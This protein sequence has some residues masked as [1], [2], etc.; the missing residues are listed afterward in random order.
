M[1]SARVTPDHGTIISEI[2]IAAPPERV[3]KA[4]SDA[5]EIRRRGPNL[6]V[7]EMDTRVGGKW[8]LEMPCPKPYKG[9]EVIRHGGEILELDPPRLLV[10]TWTANFHKDPNARSIVRWELT[11]TKSGTHVKL[12]HSGLASEPEACKDYAGGWPG[13]L[14]ELKTFSEKQA[15]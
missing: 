10:Y 2:D 12:T 1:A 3:F 5:D 7:F 8:L 4:I 9:F 13:V 14:A 11:P 6:G 15:T